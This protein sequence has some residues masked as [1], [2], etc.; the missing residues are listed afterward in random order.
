[1]IYP[2]IK[3]NFGKSS[4][5]KHEATDFSFLSEH[6]KFNTGGIHVEKNKMIAPVIDLSMLDLTKNTPI[7]PALNN[8]IFNQKD[9][10][11]GTKNLTNVSLKMKNLSIVHGW[12]DV[13]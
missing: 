7:T 9:L 11:V 3:I 10:S 2:E 5:F 12:I 6:S 8:F 1:M 4:T 13:E